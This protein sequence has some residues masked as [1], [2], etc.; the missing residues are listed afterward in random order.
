MA[1]SSPILSNMKS[2][3][4]DNSCIILRT[5]ETSIVRYADDLSF[6]PHKGCKGQSLGGHDLLVESHVFVVKSLK[7]ELDDIFAKHGLNIQTKKTR[8]WVRHW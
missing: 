1:L 5:E 2:A 6:S 8:L 7:P 4:M 3:T